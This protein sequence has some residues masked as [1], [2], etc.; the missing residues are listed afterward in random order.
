MN[1]AAE[2]TDGVLRSTWARWGS[3]V[4]SLAAI[5]FTS[6]FSVACGKGDSLDG[7]WQ[8]DNYGTRVEIAGDKDCH[9]V[10]QRAGA[11]NEVYRFPRGQEKSFET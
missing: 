9:P 3:T 8:P 2:K 4:F 5:L 6:V 1:M 7:A 11:G 10:A